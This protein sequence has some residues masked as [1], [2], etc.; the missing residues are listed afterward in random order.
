MVRSHLPTKQLFLI[1][2][3][4]GF[5]AESLLGMGIGVSLWKPIHISYATL[6]DAKEELVVLEKKSLFVKDLERTL[7]AEEPNIAKIETVFLK[8]SGV[9]TF[10]EQLEH[11]ADTSNVRISVDAADLAHE[12]TDPFSI[13][14]LTVHG[15]FSDIYQF[16]SLLESMM[17]YARIP[18]VSFTAGDTTTRAA[19]T[20][21]VLTAMP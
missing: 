17:P 4:G 12:D 20:L 18:A 10:L 11:L 7:R 9:V 2:L 6:R 21:S 5:V 19:L 16:I 8:P 1:I 14:T 3:I 13:F 15:T